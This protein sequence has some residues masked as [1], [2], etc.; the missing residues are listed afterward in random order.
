M[1]ILDEEV[2]HRMY[3]DAL[4][5]QGM[6]G[7]MG[8]MVDP[9]MPAQ[10]PGA[11]PMMAPPQPGALPGGPAAAPPP[12][13]L[14]EKLQANTHSLLEDLR[15]KVNP[16]PQGYDGLLSPDEI[17]GQQ[18]GL[19]HSLFRPGMAPG[20]SEYDTNLMNLLKRKQ[21]AVGVDHANTA[22]AQSQ[23]VLANRQKTGEILK[24]LP[25]SMPIVDKLERAALIHMQNGDL[26]AAHQAAGDA[27]DFGAN[28]APKAPPQALKEVDAGNQVHMVDPVSGKIVVTYPK[29]AVPK[30]PGE[31]TA[32]QKFS[33]DQ[34]NKILDDFRADPSAKEYD[35]ALS[36]YHVLKGAL[37]NPGIGDPM[38]ITEGIARVLN[39]GASVR[40]GMAQM[41]KDNFGGAPDKVKRW[42]QQ[43]ENG[44]WPKDLVQAIQKK[45]KDVMDQ[46]A[47]AYNGARRLAVLRAQRSGINI[48][49][50]LHNPSDEGLGV[51]VP[52]TTPEQVV[53]GNPDKVRKAGM[54]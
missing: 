45:A 7:P 27:K 17:A 42:V 37:A 36:G 21:M 34:T 11:P 43:T 10:A 29:G 14:W 4:G 1:S 33:A 53:K 20:E 47:N 3:D 32:G 22:Y 46:R 49:P 44:T 23:R 50:L 25:E 48:E 52:K 38:A 35:Q 18:P 9:G 13:S 54:R 16:T 19:M 30:T 2:S 8:A 24:Q 5:P 40:V 26:E 15:S 31:I 6:P 41:I 51:P 28:H 12:P 39:P